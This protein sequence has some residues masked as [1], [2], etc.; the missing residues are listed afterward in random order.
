MDGEDG[1]D[2]QGTTNR[3]VVAKHLDM[4]M[5]VHVLSSRGKDEFT[6]GVHQGQEHQAREF[7]LGRNV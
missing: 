5:F 3:E 6:A 1:Y 7:S 4:G 2:E